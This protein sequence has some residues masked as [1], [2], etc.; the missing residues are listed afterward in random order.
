MDAGIETDRSVCVVTHPLSTASEAAVGGLLG[1][2][3]AAASSV[4]LI[5]ANLPEDSDV[6][7]SY[8]VCEISSSETGESVGTAAVRFI[9]NQI[10]MCSE[11]RRRDEEIVLFF[12]AVSYLLPILLSRLLGKRVIVEP[13]GNVP[14]SL[15]R[16]WADRLPDRLAFLLSRP[17]W[18]LERAGY[19][20]S[21]A[22]LLLSPSMADDLDLQAPRYQHKIHEH[23]ARPV[24]IDRFAPTTPFADRERTIGYLGRLD[25]EKGV[26]VLTEVVKQLPDDIE[27]VF[28]GDGTLRPRIENELAEKIDRGSVRLP[29]WVDHDEVP[30]FL[31]SF[32]L[33]VMTS[34]TEG[35][36]TTALESMACGTPVCATPV[37]GIPDVVHDGET[38]WLLEDESAAEIA[39]RIERLV[40]NDEQLEAAS[41]RARSFVVEQYGFDA[42]VEKYRRVFASVR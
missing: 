9:R 24:D 6:W 37:G 35:V 17:V 36:P 26:D 42:V 1:V 8:E 15:Y 3:S 31:G 25:E 2:V 18:L 23:G 4:S 11:L 22:I 39:A 30:A 41:Q 21:D 13:R 32:R 28:V 20:A 29:G 5:T 7:D 14:D 19:L 12:G 27:F 10:R 34:R 38:G 40:R 33:L 16:I